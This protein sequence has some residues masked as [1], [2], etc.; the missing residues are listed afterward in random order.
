MRAAVTIEPRHLVISDDYPMPELQPGDVLV[1]VELCG[2]CGSDLMDWYVAQKVPTVLGHEIV[3][4]VVTVDPDFDQGF[5]PR[6]RVFVHHHVPC[7]TCRLCERGKETLC[8]G[9]RS[10]RIEPGGFAEF[11]RVPSAHVAHGL[12]HLPE[13]LPS[14]VATMIEPLACC[15]RGVKSTGVRRGDRALVIGLG[16]MGQLYGRAL[17]AE[18]VSVLGTDLLADRRALAESVGIATC[19]PSVD[20]IVSVGPAHGEWDLIVLCTAHA[21]AFA[22][23]FAVAGKGSVLQLF[24]PPPPGGHLSFDA[25]RLFFDEI[26]LQASYSAAPVDTLVAVS[27]LASG[28]V[29][30]AGM[31]SHRY[32]LELADEAMDTARRADSVMKVVV[33]ASSPDR[34][35]R[36]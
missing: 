2:I 27:L 14:E 19:E 23:G 8:P 16:Q 5:S 9:F 28:R 21:D 4:S 10:S 32:P 20:K 24:A 3:G 15:V 12:L 30:T 26:T 25:N 33:E 22:I 29:D 17:I 7:G 31:V 1:K 13:A 36:S 6:D 35:G 11:V 18:G 34:N